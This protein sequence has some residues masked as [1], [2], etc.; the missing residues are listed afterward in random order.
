MLVEELA[1][2][3]DRSVYFTSSI[4]VTSRKQKA[5]SGQENRR[6][7]PTPGTYNLSNIETNLHGTGLTEDL[8]TTKND[9]KR[10][11]ELDKENY[12]DTKIDLPKI[13]LNFEYKRFPGFDRVQQGP[14][15][16]RLK[17]GANASTKKI[18]ASRKML[19]NYLDED[20][21]QASIQFN[22]VSKKQLKLLMVPPKKLCSICGDNA[23]SSCTRCLARICCVKCSRIHNESRCTNYY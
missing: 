18:L 23:P 2:N 14:K 12:N 21:R 9:L 8:Q 4:N 6:K 19:S 11:Q 22:L 5:S 10:F 13:G 1:R 7:R 20:E 16:G 3:A 17:T 15:G